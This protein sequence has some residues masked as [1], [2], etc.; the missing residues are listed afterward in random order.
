MQS[1][2]LWSRERAVS[3]RKHRRTQYDSE[4]IQNPADMP[5]DV[6]EKFASA[7]RSLHRQEQGN[8]AESGCPPALLRRPYSIPR[9]SVRTGLVRWRQGEHCVGVTGPS[10]GALGSLQPGR[11]GV[12]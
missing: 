2:K 10:F 5:S 8:R 1:I 7:S 11:R 9:R 4:L 3:T 6:A 12:A